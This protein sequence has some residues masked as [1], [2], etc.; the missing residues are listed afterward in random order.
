MLDY[1]KLYKK[2]L[3]ENIKTFWGHIDSKSTQ[4]KI[5][6]FAKKF[7]LKPEEVKDK[8]LHDEVFALSFV[9][10]PGRQSI[11]EKVAE[12]YISHMQNVKL[13][14]NLPSSGKN[15]FWISNGSIVSKNPKNNIKSIDFK[16][17][18]KKD[19]TIWALHKYTNE[20][21]GAQ[22]NQFREAKLFIKEACKQ[23]HKNIVFVAILDGNYYTQNKINQIK[24]LCQKQNVFILN[25]E[26]LRQKIENMQI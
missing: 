17:E 25:I 6:N 19:N 4:I 18:T 9:K 14:K 5:N 13:I 16:I 24:K 8:I 3:K 10:D 7:E 23:N 15:A 22:D 1:K 26:E 12:Q 20:A 2:A 11:H 21:G